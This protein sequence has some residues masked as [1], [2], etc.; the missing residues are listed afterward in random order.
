MWAG[1]NRSR[2]FVLDRAM[3][4]EPKDVG[5]DR[6]ELQRLAYDYCEIAGLSGERSEGAF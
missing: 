3:R 6:Q 4:K 2:P 1:L 5:R